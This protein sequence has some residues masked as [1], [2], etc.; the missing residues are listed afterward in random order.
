MW[1]PGSHF[2]K[3]FI[4]PKVWESPSYW[5]CKILLQQPE[6]YS[7]AKRIITIFMIMYRFGLAE[8]FQLLSQVY[9]LPWKSE[10]NF[11]TASLTFGIQ[12]AYRK[13]E[14]RELQ[15]VAISHM[16]SKSQDLLFWANYRKFQSLA[17]LLDKF[18]I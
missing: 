5:N 13:N 3:W 8:D 6:L 15:K 12:E 7:Y 17:I 4:F 14:L 9:Y 10:R 11:K 16:G 18:S 1:L 2:S